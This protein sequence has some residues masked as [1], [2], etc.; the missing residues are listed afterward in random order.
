VPLKEDIRKILTEKY[1]A[2]LTKL[3]MVNINYFIKELI[4]WAGIDAPVTITHKR[5][6][7]SLKK[8]APIRLST[9]PYDPQPMN[10][11]PVPS[12]T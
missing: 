2:H 10:T 1:D 12:G 9:L 5:A 3:S 6:T 11:W 7:T 4:N 8:P